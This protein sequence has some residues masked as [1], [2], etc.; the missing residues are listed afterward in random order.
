MCMFTT[1]IRKIIVKTKFILKIILL[2]H[3]FCPIIIKSITA[4]DGNHLPADLML[5]VNPDDS[6]TLNVQQS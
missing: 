5:L 1:K 2:I 6:F 3:R 4:L